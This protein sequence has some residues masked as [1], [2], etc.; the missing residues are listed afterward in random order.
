MN[1]KLKDL[2]LLIKDLVDG[3]LDIDDIEEFVYENFDK[4]DEILEEINNWLE[5]EEF[6]IRELMSNIKL[7]ER[8]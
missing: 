4:A 5:E 6:N 7:I 1:S 3:F 2:R 8:K